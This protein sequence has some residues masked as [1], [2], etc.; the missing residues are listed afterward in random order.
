MRIYIIIT[1]I[2]LCFQEEFKA[3]QCSNDSTG[4]VP[5]S[6]LGQ[7]TFLGMS[8]G[9]YGNASN[10][11]P[12]NHKEQGVILAQEIEPLSATG[13]P[14]EDGKIGFISMGMSNCNL[15]FGKFRDSALVYSELNPKLRLVNCATGGFDIDALLN[16]SGNYWNSVNQKMV[17]AGLTDLQV[18]VIW[19]EQ[20]KHISG[21]PNGEGVEHI[22]LMEEKFL[23]AFMYFKQKYPNLK[24]V[25]CSGRDYGGYSMPG[26]GNPEPYAYYTNWAFRKLI[27]RQLLGDPALD[28][29]G[30]DANVTWLAWANHIWSDGSNARDD[31]F[32]WLCPDDFQS[33]GV[34][35][36][37]NGQAK[38]AHLL[39]DFFKSDASTIW[40][41]NREITVSEKQVNKVNFMLY[42]NP[43]NGIIKINVNNHHNIN[44]EIYNLLGELVLKGSGETIH[45]EILPKGIFTLCAEVDGK[46]VGYQKF[47]KN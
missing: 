27:D 28:Y 24:Q 25:F 5:I 13:F 42:P 47:V 3:Q 15:F 29:L 40:F 37:Q 46:K 6:D 1:F 16:F 43:S 39:M 7:A 12:L 23:Q 4:L 14:D 19:F 31:G 17:Q 11:M 20:A 41:N 36:N 22:E 26:S 44:Y 9:L 45:T 34:H 10:E 32:S 38:V 18:Q 21:I 30:E 2:F 33:D 35:P 8:G